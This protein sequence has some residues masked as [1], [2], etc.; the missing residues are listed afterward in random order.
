M[1]LTLLGTKQ[2]STAQHPAARY[3]AF[4]RVGSVKEA[5][6][7]PYS[8]PGNCSDSS[9]LCGMK[10]KLV[11]DCGIPSQL[12]LN[13]E[14]CNCFSPL[15]RSEMMAPTWQLAMLPG[16]LSQRYVSSSPL[17]TQCFTPSP[18]ISIKVRPCKCGPSFGFLFLFCFNIAEQLKLAWL[19]STQ[20]SWIFRS[21]FF[22]SIKVSHS[23]K[24]GRLDIKFFNAILR[25]LHFQICGKTSKRNIFVSSRLVE[26]T[27]ERAH[28]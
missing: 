2:Q 10:Q 7:I 5:M 15:C 12:T 23:Q 19:Y 16:C 9:Q 13:S 21:I 6:Q 17:K 28:R 20:A 11:A 4:P 22:L 8:K 14:A 25:M 24:K 26:S 27:E 1:I 18:R 3:S